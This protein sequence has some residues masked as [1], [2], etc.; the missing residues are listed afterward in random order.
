M[1]EFTGTD[2]A[3]AIIEYWGEHAA[4]LPTGIRTKL[5]DILVQTDTLARI[6]KGMEAFYAVRGELN[7]EG[8]ELLGK[9]ARFVGLHNFY[10]KGERAALI[11]GVVTRIENG[12][13]AELESDPVIDSEF[14]E[15]TN[16][17]P[18]I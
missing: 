3:R 2:A 16:E 5:S 15:Q 12:G 1:T 14:V 17:V 18:S 7:P 6:I 9:L 10:G 4:V 11:A 8:L 13:D